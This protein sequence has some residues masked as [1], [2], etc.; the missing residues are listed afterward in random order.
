MR[1]DNLI[2]GTDPSG[3]ILRITP[4]GQGFVLYQAP[5]RE[6]TAVAVAPDGTIYAAG[7]GN[8][9]P[10]PASIPAP[11]PVPSPTPS[12]STR[13]G[14]SAAATPPSSADA[15]GAIP[16]DHRR[17]GNLSHSDRRL[18]RA[19]C[20]AMPQ[21]LVY[22]LAFDA[23]GRP[24]AGTGNHGSIYPHRF[25]SFLHAAAEPRADAGDRH[26]APRRADASTRSPGT[27][28]R[29]FRSGRRSNRRALCESDVFDA[30]AFSYWGRLSHEPK[31]RPGSVVFETRSG[32]L[33][34]PQK[35]WSAWAKLNAGANRIAAGA[36]PAIP[37]RPLPGRPKWTKSTSPIR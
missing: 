12:G 9:Q 6:I 8:K 27:S 25:R 21:D 14:R 24:I 10:T 3:L 15:G 11:A 22:A 29:F 36:I 7:V 32:N 5:K 23:Q 16:R 2:V 13:G 34:R 26:S 28:A 17:L 30:G 37:A 33:N 20:G 31:P 1:D 19:K 35:N 4:A 18:S